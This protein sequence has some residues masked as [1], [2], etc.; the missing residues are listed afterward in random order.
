MENGKFSRGFLNKAFRFIRIAW[1][2]N[3]RFIKTRF[4]RCKLW[5]ARKNMDER[6]ARLG[7]EIYSLYRQNEKEFLKSLVVRQ[8]LKIVEEAER[9]VF[10]IYDRLEETEKGYR[11]KKERLFPGE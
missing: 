4:Y 7:T 11:E 3:L 8:Q 6:L 1:A 10:E 2:W 9:H 5:K